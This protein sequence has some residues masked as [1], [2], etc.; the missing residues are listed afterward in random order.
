LI[1]GVRGVSLTSF[2]ATTIYQ[3]DVT[4][5][6][7]VQNIINDENGVSYDQSLNFTLWKQDIFTTQ[8]LH[9]ATTIDLRYI[10][11]LNDGRYQIGGLFGGAR[12]EFDMNTGGSKGD[13]NG[14]N[15]R[16]VGQ[17]LFKAAFIDNLASAG[18]TISAEEFLL[19]ES[20]FNL[21]L[22]NTNLIEL[23]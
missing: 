2:P 8:E 7:F 9:L 17:E 18:F 23:G 15:V 16:L 5:A 10:I 14:Y 11:E 6:N 19:T 3:Y 12:L 21:L 20:G 13:L 1:Q 22:E 4:N